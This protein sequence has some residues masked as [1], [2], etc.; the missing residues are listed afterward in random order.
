MFFL[1]IIYSVILIFCF[2]SGLCPIDTCSDE[3]KEDFSCF[4]QQKYNTE[5]QQKSIKFCVFNKFTCLVNQPIN[6]SQNCLRN[7][8]NYK[9]KCYPKD[10]KPMSYSILPNQTDF[11]FS[12]G[13]TL[14]FEVLYGSSNPHP[15]SKLQF[16]IGS[17][18]ETY[19]INNKSRYIYN[20]VYS[21]PIKNFGTYSLKIFQPAYQD[22]D[23][24]LF[25]ITQGH[26]YTHSK[27]NLNLHN[28]VEN[29]LCFSFSSVLRVLIL[30]FLLFLKTI[31]HD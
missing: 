18:N 16:E 3:Y 28:E 11:V 2:A 1:Q 30:C 7:Q 25:N 15:F 4:F 31:N 14:T 23:E 17:K 12:E 21:F 26:Y 29:L 10:I 24:V 9:W 5:N 13:D 8:T 27:S 19:L 6:F 22:Y 20:D